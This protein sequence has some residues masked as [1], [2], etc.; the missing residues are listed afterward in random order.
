MSYY[1]KYTK[2]TAPLYMSVKVTSVALNSEEDNVHEYGF[3]YTDYLEEATRFE[4]SHQAVCM[5]MDV[6][7]VLE[8]CWDVFPDL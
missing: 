8:D 3:N 7:G 2:S 4:F 1:I 5:L 6:E